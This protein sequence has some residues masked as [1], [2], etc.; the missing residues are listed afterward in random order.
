MRF[1][2]N[3]GI[4]VRS[5]RSLRCNFRAFSGQ[6]AITG[7]YAVKGENFAATAQ[8]FRFRAEIELDRFPSVASP[9]LQ[10][11]CR[12]RFVTAVH[13]AIF[14]ATIARD[15]LHDPILVPLG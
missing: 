14:A 9:R 10:S 2:D 6:V 12:C 5:L 7:T 11:Q 4:S 8:G 1:F 3:S 13:H 15:S